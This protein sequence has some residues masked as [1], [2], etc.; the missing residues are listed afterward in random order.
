MKA[1]FRRPLQA[2]FDSMHR[3]AGRGL[4]HCAAWL[5][6]VL[7]AL[8]WPAQAQFA[9]GG[10]GL[11]RN[12]I[13]WFSWG[14]NG[15]AIANGTSRSISYTVAGQVFVVTC[16][17]NNIAMQ[18]GTGGVFAYRS[19]NFAGDGLDNLYNIG[20]VDT[21]NALIVGIR[22]N[23]GANR[24]TFDV[25]CSATLDGAAVN[26]NGLVFAEAETSINNEL[27]ELTTAGMPRLI[28]RFRSC[29]T[30]SSIATRSGNTT[31]MSGQNTTYCGGGGANGGPMA[32]LFVENDAARLTGSVRLGALNNAGGISAIA[33]GV[34]ADGVDVGD[35]PASYGQASHFQNTIFSGGAIPAGSTNVSTAALGTR[36]LPSVRLGAT[37]DV[38]TTEYGG[39]GA[40][41]DD[42][43]AT[44]DEDG[45]TATV[46]PSLLPGDTLIRSVTCSPAG[47]FVHGWIDFNLDGDFS[48]AGE[49]STTVACAGG[50]AS[51]SWTVPANAR[52]GSSYVRFRIAN[53][54]ADVAAP[55]GPAATGEVED[56]VITLV[57][58]A[59]LAIAKSNTYTPV[60][61]SD[62][63]GDTVTRGT[64]VAY[65]LTV[66][67]NGP[68]AVTGAVVKDTPTAGITCPGANTVFVDYSGATPDATSDIA[69]LTGSGVALGQLGA[70]ETA[71]LTFNC[72]V[73]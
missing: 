39:T 56:H 30:A 68:A 35:A 27:V 14:A 60:Q 16:T 34:M 38:D 25:T 53:A 3:R 66:T 65:T 22:T 54:A 2:A 69:T 29:T 32:V 51:L 8:S 7:G 70:N 47:A 26:L 10:S 23:N 59:D 24:A 45:F 1:T 62:L 41:G 28:D 64:T 37:A 48:D 11:Y 6:L 18:A 21:A 17:I 67:N 42:N 73:N 43:N 9:T 55:S 40:V 61:P 57:Q 46:T 12:D 52:H 33:I 4:G 5:L 44:D 36:T 31:S 63:P 19:G 71:T 20:G 15:A 72:T 49:A 13:L 58:S 50:S